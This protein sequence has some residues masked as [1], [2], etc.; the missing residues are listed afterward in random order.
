MELIFIAILFGAFIVFQVFQGRKRRRDT[1]ERQ[2]QFVPGVEVMTNFG[3]YGTI[4]EM[5]EERNLVTL[6]T[7]PGS[8]VKIHRQT[9]LKIADYDTVPEIDESEDVSDD[10]VLDEKGEIVVDDT[11]SSRAIEPDFGERV[12]PD[13]TTDGPRTKRVDE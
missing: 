10:V 6:E 13:S 1:E 7:S 5:D 4:V 2:T 8:T 12:D 3:L 11:R 9:I